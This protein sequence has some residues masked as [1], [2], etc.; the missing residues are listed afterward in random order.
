MGSVGRTDWFDH[1]PYPVLIVLLCTLWSPL[2][3]SPRCLRNIPCTNICMWSGHTSPS[4]ISTPFHWHNCLNISL[5]AWRFSSKNTFRLYFGANT[6]WYLQF[7]FVCARL[8]VFIFS[9]FKDK[10]SSC[11]FCGWQTTFILPHEEDFFSPVNLSWTTRLSRGFHYT[12]KH[13]HL[14]Q[15]PMF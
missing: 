15:M 5:I 9:F 2:C 8:F 4:I 6:M 14:S 11:V 7:H 1:F 3:S 13:R 12:K 10:S